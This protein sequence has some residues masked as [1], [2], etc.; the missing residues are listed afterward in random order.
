MLDFSL[1]EERREGRKGVRGRRR[2]EGKKKKKKKTE[3]GD[4]DDGQR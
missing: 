2:E 4:D 1:G 3:E